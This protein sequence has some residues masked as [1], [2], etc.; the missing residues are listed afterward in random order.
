MNPADPALPAKALRREEPIQRVAVVGTGLI[1]SSWAALFLAHGLDVTATDPAVDAERTLRNYVQRVWPTLTSLG[2]AAGA[3]L[4][5]L[6]FNRD[7]AAGVS[8]AQFV[9]EN[10]PEQEDF[11]IRLFAE[12]DRLLPESTLLASSSSGCTMSTI[13]SGC[14]HPERCVIG[15]P[16]NPP[17][18]IPLVELVGGRATAPEAIDRADV[19]YTRLGKRTIRL[20]KEMPG[21]VANR[22]QA[23]LWREAVHLVAEGVVS[24]ADV[25]TAVSS[26]P[27]L[28]WALMGPH[29]NL[30]LGGGQGGMAHF[31]DHLSGPFTRWWADLGEPVLTPELKAAIIRGVLEEAAGRSIDT[32]AKNRDDALVRLLEIKKNAP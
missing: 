24:V 10:G 28:R 14:R 4:D 5:R 13:Q 17:H 18:L 12:L 15:H 27:G 31:M 29:M 2:L 23:A 25:D 19:F 9:Q 16:F 26:G 3:S 21:H 8:G 7:L 1:G 11:K 22:L 20:N 6:K 32:L 30:H